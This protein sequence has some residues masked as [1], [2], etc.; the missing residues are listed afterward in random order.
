VNTQ[1]QPGAPLSQLRNMMKSMSV[2]TLSGIDEHGALLSSPMSRWEMD[3]SGAL[4]FFTDPQ[5]LPAASLPSIN[6]S[7]AD[8]GRTRRVSLSG[9][10][11]LYAEDLSSEYLLGA[12][13]LGHINSPRFIAQAKLN[14]QAL[15]KFTPQ[16]AV[17]W[18]APPSLM[19]RLLALL[20]SVFG[21]KKASAK[22][23]IQCVEL[24]PAWKLN[25]SEPTT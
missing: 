3:D 25:T 17:Y 14:N 23:G 13:W 24:T 2:A 5:C 20:S 10:A 9:Q 22:P 12:I 21:A 18:H 1:N 19:A 15:L 11:E 16:S 8:P 7:F 6:L 4:W